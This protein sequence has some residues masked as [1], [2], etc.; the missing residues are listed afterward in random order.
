MNYYFVATENFHQSE[1]ENVFGKNVGK[2]AMIVASR[3]LDPCD[4]AEAVA[5]VD[6]DALLDAAHC[7]GCPPPFDHQQHHLSGMSSD[8][9]SP[10]RIPS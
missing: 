6:G 5:F 10:V 1:E 2:D 3:H 7:V 9:R 8:Q 4:A